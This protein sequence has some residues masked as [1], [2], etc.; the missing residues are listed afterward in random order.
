[1]LLKPV[2]LEF[3]DLNSGLSQMESVSQYS[4][5]ELV[6]DK[7]TFIYLSSFLLMMQF[8]LYFPG[9]YAFFILQ[10]CMRT[11]TENRW[12]HNKKNPLIR[13]WEHVYFSTELLFQCQC[14]VGDEQIQFAPQTF[15]PSIL[16]CLLSHLFTR[17]DIFSIILF[18]H[19]AFEWSV[20]SILL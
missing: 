20:C 19:P 11:W 13:L 9:W 10:V 3:D 14:C 5:S 15:C 12:T 17:Y 8:W 1:M 4:W 18:V 7:I 16:G 2:W 6:S